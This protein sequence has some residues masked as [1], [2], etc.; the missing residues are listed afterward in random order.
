MIDQRMWVL[1]EDNNQLYGSEVDDKNNKVMEAAIPMA[2]GAGHIQH[3]EE[4]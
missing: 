2:R 4:K 1:S 3:R